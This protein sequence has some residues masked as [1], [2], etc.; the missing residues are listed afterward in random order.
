[1]FPTCRYDDDP[2]PPPVQ[3]PPPSPPLG[4]KL[5]KLVNGTYAQNWGRENEEWMS[6]FAEAGSAAVT[7]RPL[8]CTGC[9]WDSASGTAASHDGKNVVLT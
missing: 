1:M 9:C 7:I 6:V 8:N 3:P 5:A 2:P 4:S